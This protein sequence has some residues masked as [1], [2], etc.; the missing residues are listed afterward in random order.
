MR[1][2]R[3]SLT[4]ILLMISSTILIP[5][6]LAIDSDGDGMPDE[7]ETL[8]GLN[9]QDPSDANMD[10]DRDG[11]TNL[12]E[13]QNDT[14]PTT[15]FSGGRVKIVH[16][17]ANAGNNQMTPGKIEELLSHGVNGFITNDYSNNVNYSTYPDHLPT[18]IKERAALAK[19]Y[20][21]SFFQ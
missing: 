20:N 19:Q 15:P 7:W 14:I 17:Y 21:F 11:L 13:Y 18:N 9:P 1:K 12:R 4:I 16:N 5:S 8:Y 10:L 3:G 2:K 6:C